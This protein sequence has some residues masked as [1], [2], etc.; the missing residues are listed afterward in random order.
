MGWVEVAEMYSRPG[1][2]HGLEHFVSRYHRNRIVKFVATSL[3]QSRGAGIGLTIDGPKG[4]ATTSL[5]PAGFWNVSGLVA[6]AHQKID[7]IHCTRIE[8]EWRSAHSV[9]AR[10][11]P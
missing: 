5:S 3:L 11:G 1:L 4:P 7:K 8:I 10:F 9:Y 6:C 2:S